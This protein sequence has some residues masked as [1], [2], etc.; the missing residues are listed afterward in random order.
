VKQE[1]LHAEFRSAEKT[2]RQ[3]RKKPERER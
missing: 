2:P 3:R 1:I